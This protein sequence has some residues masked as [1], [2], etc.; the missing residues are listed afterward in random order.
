VLCNREHLIDIF[1]IRLANPEH[2]SGAP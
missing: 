2:D 1:T